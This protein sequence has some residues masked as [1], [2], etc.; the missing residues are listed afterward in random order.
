MEPSRFPLFVYA[1]C[2]REWLAAYNPTKYKH[3]LYVAVSNNHPITH[4]HEAPAGHSCHL[5]LI[6]VRVLIYPKHLAYSSVSLLPLLQISD[7]SMPCTSP[8]CYKEPSAF[9]T[10]ISPGLSTAWCL[11]WRLGLRAD[12]ASAMEKYWWQF[13]ASQHNIIDLMIGENE[14]RESADEMI[15]A[16]PMS[17]GRDERG[18]RS[19]HLW[20][21]HGI[22]TRPLFL[23]FSDPPKHVVFSHFAICMLFSF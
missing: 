10:G 14:E 7:P 18:E 16:L 19:G 20:I 12:A 23:S 11:Q 4:G 2:M 13:L 22:S 17:R 9:F 5:R 15:H 3:I 21:F 6:P 8:F 1:G